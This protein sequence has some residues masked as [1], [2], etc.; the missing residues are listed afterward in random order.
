MV[1]RGKHPLCIYLSACLLHFCLWL[2]HFYSNFFPHNIFNPVTRWFEY[3]L[4]I[5][6]KR[7]FPLDFCIWGIVWN[8]LYIQRKQKSFK[9][10][11][12]EPCIYLS[13]CSTSICDRFR[14][15]LIFFSHTTLFLLQTLKYGMLLIWTW[16]HKW[17]TW[18]L[19]SSIVEGVFLLLVLVP[20]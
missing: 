14:L 11:S 4:I 2:L 20:P 17:Q 12:L 18:V 19:N 8:C 5:H 3:G 7:I 6:E 9:L 10:C 1:Q 16:F 15:V 13:V